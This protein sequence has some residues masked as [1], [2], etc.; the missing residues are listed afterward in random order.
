MRVPGYEP[1][2]LDKKVRVRRARAP[3]L[4]GVVKPTPSR[5]RTQVH[6]RRNS[7]SIAA[8]VKAAEDAGKQRANELAA[9]S[10]SASKAAKKEPE[11][12]GPERKA[13]SGWARLKARR[14]I[15]QAFQAPAREA[16]ALAKG[17]GAQRDG[18]GTA[19]LAVPKASPRRPVRP[20]DPN[21]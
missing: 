6:R 8:I 18:A 11:G 3:C 14:R 10:S 9:S 12:A 5:R 21:T 16:A 4:F 17:E 13:G 7:T 15:V 19:K 2:D 20:H 1:R